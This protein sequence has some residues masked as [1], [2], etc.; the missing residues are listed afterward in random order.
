M[1]EKAESNKEDGKGDTMSVIYSEVAA[2]EPTTNSF[3]MPNHYQ[4]TV[5]R[6][7]DGYRVCDQI[8]ACFQE[9]AKIE[10][11]YALMIDEWTRKWRPLVDAG[12]A[13]GTLLHAW[14][15]FLG[16]S[17][18]LSRL[19]ME[20]QRALVSEDAGRIRSWQ[21]DSYHRKLFGGFKEACELENGFQRAQKPW[22]KKLKK[23]EKAKT[24]YHKACRK[25]YIATLRES[26]IQIAPGAEVSPDRQ[27]T[28]R[29]EHQRCSQETNKVRE[30]YEKALQELDRCSPRYIEEM[31]CVFEQGQALEQ[32]RIVFLKSAFLALHRRLDIT[33]DSSVQAVYSDLHQAIEEINDQEDLK[34]WHNRNGPGMP[35]NWP[36]FEDWSPDHERPQIKIKKTKE[37]EKVIPCSITPIQSCPKPAPVPIAGQRVRAVYDYIGQEADELSFKAGELLTKLEDED[38][39][40]WCKGVTDSGHVGLYPAN[41][42]EPIQEIESTLP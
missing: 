29:E 18:R 35:M 10:R 41:Y 13:Y 33:A 16:A 5:K 6:L 31:E 39:Q 28:L 40:G 1:K 17:E 38:E 4:N 22:T 42:V 12:P 15:A 2:D 20:M 30:R 21:H 11:N 24:L 19:H 8:V 32:R 7:D 37:P 14:Q 26:G 23:A 34:W 25:E 9:R 27:R 36:K 3:W